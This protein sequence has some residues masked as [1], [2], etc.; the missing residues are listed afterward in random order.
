MNAFHERPADAT[1][2]AVADAVRDRLLGEVD[3]AV[4]MHDLDLLETRIGQLRASFPASTLHAFAIKANPLVELLTRAVKHG[5]GLEAASIE[6]VHLALAAGCPPNRIVF[7]SPAKTRA[8]I[9]FALERGIRLNADNFDELDRIVDERPEDSTSIIGLRLNPLIGDGRIPTTSVAGSSSK[10]GERIDSVAE[11]LLAR[12]RRHPFL[13]CLHFHIGSQGMALD[14]FAAAAERVAAMQHLLNDSLGRHQFD[15][16]DVGGGASTD[17]T[18]DD[19]VDPVMIGDSLRLAAPC[20]FDGSTELVTEFGRAVLANCGWAL[21]RVEYVKQID[22]RPMAVVHL[23]ADMLMRPVY[24]PEHWRHR[25]SA[26][27]ESGRVRSEKTDGWTVSGPLCFAADIVGREADLSADVQPGDW[28]VVHD[29]GAYTLSMW[30]RHCNRAMP[31]A[32]GYEATDDGWW[33]S[34]LRPRERPEDV[35]AFWS[36]GPSGDR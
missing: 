13:R 1:I 18:G 8:E 24:Q 11:P 23:G 14:A 19:V 10:F 36:S 31:A 2:T 35:V 20:W 32:Y 21:T 30:S 22:G 15:V 6:E 28:L 5:M 34:L 3:T 12:A 25:F 29:A 9:R 4:V 17:Y 26:L 16:V 7:D 33:F 27:P